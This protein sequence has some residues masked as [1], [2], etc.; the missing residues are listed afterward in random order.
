MGIVETDER[1]HEGYEISCEMAK[2]LNH[3]QSSLATENIERSA[4]I[5]F[6]PDA[7]KVDGETVRMKLKEKMA[8][9]AAFIEKLYLEQEVTEPSHCKTCFTRRRQR[10]TKLKRSRQRS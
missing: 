7:W 3:G 1:C 5:R 10:R 9:L 4:F 2:V 6:N 8:D